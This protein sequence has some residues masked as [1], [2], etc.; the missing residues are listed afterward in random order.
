MD[1]ILPILTLVLALTHAPTD[2]PP[3]EAAKLIP[4]LGS[5]KFDERESASKQLAKLGPGA[6][7]Q[8]RA[9]ATHK[10]P[11]IAARANFL[12]DAFIEK[13]IAALG[14]MPCIDG[15][16]YD[17]ADH[18]YRTEFTVYGM[19][20]WDQLEGYLASVGRDAWPWD[21]YREATRLWAVDRLADGMQPRVLRLILAE[22][23]RRDKIYHVR[24]E[25][26]NAEFIKKSREPKVE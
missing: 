23:D 26:E 21:N 19:I 17:E 2:P 5:R 6:L 15:A 9:A 24:F 8:I 13:E 22:M 1:E 3:P 25:T 14:K 4:Q 16:W 7:P 18:A 20:G 12:I 11:E 10:D